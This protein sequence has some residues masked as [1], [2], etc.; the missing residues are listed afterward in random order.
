MAPH[1]GLSVYTTVQSMVALAT[2]YGPT[3]KQAA[4]EQTAVELEA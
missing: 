2:S 1:G 4:L 3:A